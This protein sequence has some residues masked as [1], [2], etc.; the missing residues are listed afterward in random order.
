MALEERSRDKEIIRCCGLIATCPAELG[1]GQWT[2]VQKI[3][4]EFSG[5]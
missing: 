1:D 5:K 2:T 3:E 4:I